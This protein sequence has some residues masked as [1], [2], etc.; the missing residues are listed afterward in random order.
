MS[1]QQIIDAIREH[2][3]SAG[4]EFLIRFNE[5]ALQT[6]LQRLTR[7]SGHRG[8]GSVWVRSGETAAAMTGMT[9]A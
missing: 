2:N 4:Q 7:V 6:Y 1:K 5:V 3:R 9:A 8:R